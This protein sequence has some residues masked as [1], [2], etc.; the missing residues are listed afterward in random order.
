MELLQECGTKQS[1]SATGQPHD[2]AE[3]EHSL[4]PS[5]KKRRTAESTPRNRV[6]DEAW[7]STLHFI[8]KPDRTER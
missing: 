8:M 5:K 6:F 2:N 7:N 3:A 4:Q 1:F